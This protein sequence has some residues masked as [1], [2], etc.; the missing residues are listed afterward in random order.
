MN[1]ISKTLIIYLLN[2]LSE[3]MLT[4]QPH[5]ASESRRRSDTL[6]ISI[7][8]PAFTELDEDVF[9]RLINTATAFMEIKMEIKN[10]FIKKGHRHYY[11]RP[12]KRLREALLTGRVSLERLARF[13][14]VTSIRNESDDDIGEY[15][16]RLRD[17]FD[18]LLKSR[19]PMME[20]RRLYNA[21]EADG[22][23]AAML[24]VK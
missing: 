16:K 13:C 15:I 3:I 8:E 4:F 12:L 11:N 1:H 24:G 17:E 18:I 23:I 14:E 5:F 19:Y 20:A 10:V 2:I 21:G 22:F 7:A 6:N 9:T